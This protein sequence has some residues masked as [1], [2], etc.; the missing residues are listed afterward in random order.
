MIG[1]N[2]YLPTFSQSVLGLGAI[3]S[4]FIL[5]VQSLGWPLASSSSAKLYLSIGFKKT[6]LIG[7]FIMILAVFSFLLLPFEASAWWVIGNQFLLGFGFLSTPT[8]V[9]VQSIVLWNQRGVTTGS[10]MFSR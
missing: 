2:M 4:G 10:N 3:L 8:L 5:A 1:P 7:A 6:A 9:G